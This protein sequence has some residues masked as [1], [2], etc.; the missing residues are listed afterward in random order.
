MCGT[1][2]NLNQKKKSFNKYIRELP[3]EAVKKADR[4]L[5]PSKF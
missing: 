4:F 5:A 2:H 1:I 3:G